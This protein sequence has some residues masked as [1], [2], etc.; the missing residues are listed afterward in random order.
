MV[1]EEAV[2]I[3][4]IVINHKNNQNSQLPEE[5]IEII[6]GITKGIR[7]E[8]HKEGIIT[9][10]EIMM[11]DIIMAIKM[12][13]TIEIMMGIG[14]NLEEEEDIE[15]DIKAARYVKVNLKII[16]GIR[17]DNRILISKREIIHIYLKPLMKQ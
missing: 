9:I 4:E 3:E 5:E 15:V 8:E 14:V 1:P 7:K 13:I 11:E 10:Q 16:Q 12:E 2:L 6:K 17:E